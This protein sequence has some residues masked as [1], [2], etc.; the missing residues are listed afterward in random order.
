MV[1]INYVFDMADE[2]TFVVGQMGESPCKQKE[3]KFCFIV[4]VRD[5]GF[6]Y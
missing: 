1:V 6:N 4:I 2:V 3:V 5:I